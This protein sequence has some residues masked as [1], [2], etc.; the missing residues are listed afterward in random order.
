MTTLGVIK[1]WTRKESAEFDA[2]VAAAKKISAVTRRRW[3]K[4]PAVPAKKRT[5]A[6]QKQT[7]CRKS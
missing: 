7:K 2:S 5:F 1:V 4:Q 6:T 3:F